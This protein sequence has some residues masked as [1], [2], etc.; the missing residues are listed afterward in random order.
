M[1]VEV[2][3]DISLLHH[4]LDLELLVVLAAAA[5]LMHQEPV[6]QVEMEIRHLHLLRKGIMVEL[7]QWI[8]VLLHSMVTLAVAVVVLVAVELL[9]VSQHPKER[10][11]M[12]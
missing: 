6:Q 1:A 8:Q 3:V 10:V 9:V 5:L 11:E 7:D 2:V 4:H 12:E